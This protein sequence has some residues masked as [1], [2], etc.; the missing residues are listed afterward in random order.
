MA[1]SY[2]WPSDT[3]SEGGPPGS[4]PQLTTGTE[5]MECETADKKGLL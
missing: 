3:M 5:T 4:G 1:L 2:C